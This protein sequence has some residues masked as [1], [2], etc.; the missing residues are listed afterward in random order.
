M[1]ATHRYR[2]WAG[3]VGVFVALTA[4]G[5]SS[6]DSPV[7]STATSD[8]DSARSAPASGGGIEEFTILGGPDWLA[9]D[10]D[11]LFVRRDNGGIDEIDTGTGA[12][13]A[14]V[15][16]EGDPCQGIG[17]LDGEVWTCS[18]PDVVAVDMA[19]QRVTATIPVGKSYEQGTLAGAFGRVWVLTGDGSTL[20]SIDPATD[21]VDRTIALG[22]RGTDLA[23]SDDS[24]WAV[25]LVAAAVV[26]VDPTTGVVMRTIEGLDEPTTI[27]IGGDGAVW[28]GGGTTSR[29]DPGTGEV[30]ATSPARPGPEGAL[31]VVD[32]DVLVRSEADFLQRLDGTTAESVASW[33]APEGVSSGGD[34]A[35]AGG[36]V[37]VSAYDD[38]TLVRIP[39]GDD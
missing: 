39:L 15:E 16:I 6:S 27:A 9:A 3:I 7:S 34:V 23:V 20:V 2:R 33:E 32:D 1:D 13:V 18:G 14:S 22:V 37:W 4:S 24:V 5:C 17:V 11:R 28:V 21:A 10:G 36:S 29:I 25:S 12:V 19:E 31:A 35:V 38:A 26:Q 8:A 30:T